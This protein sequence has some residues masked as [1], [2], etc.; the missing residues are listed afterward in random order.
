LIH[1]TVHYGIAVMVFSI[2]L[3]CI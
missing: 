1:D 3:M 2:L